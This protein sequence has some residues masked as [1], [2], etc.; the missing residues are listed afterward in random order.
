MQSNHH[1]YAP[2]IHPIVLTQQQ[3]RQQQPMSVSPSMLQLQSPPP[4]PQPQHPQKE[5]KPNLTALLKPLLTTKLLESGSGAKSTVASI[6]DYVEKHG[7]LPEIDLADR[8]ELMSR[9]RDNAGIEFLSAWVHDDRAMKIM[10]IWIKAAIN[11]KDAGTDD[12]NDALMAL[13]LVRRNLFPS[14]Q[15]AP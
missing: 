1:H 6:V 2:S 12:S 5:I 9:L 8:R 7:P 15:L 13:L 3:Q 11:G 10:R 4:L 14:E